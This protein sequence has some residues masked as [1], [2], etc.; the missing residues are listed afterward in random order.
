MRDLFRQGHALDRQTQE[1]F[2]EKQRDLERVFQTAT[3]QPHPK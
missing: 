3:R 1:V 2:S